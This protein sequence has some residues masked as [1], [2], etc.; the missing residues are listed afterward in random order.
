VQ[1][2]VTQNEEERGH[3]D[4]SIELTEVQRLLK[5]HDL[6]YNEEIRGFWIPTVSVIRRVAYWARNMRTFPNPAK[7]PLATFKR[8]GE[9]NA[10]A[11]NRM[12]VSCEIATA[13]QAVAPGERDDGAGKAQGFPDQWLSHR[14]VQAFRGELEEAREKMP[15]REH[16]ALCEAMYLSLYKASSE[17]GM[18]GSL[19]LRDQV[20]QV[21]NHASMFALLRTAELTVSGSGKSKKRGR[22]GGDG[23]SGPEKKKSR[24]NA[25][26]GGQRGRQTTPARGRFA[27]EDGALGPNGLARMRG[28]NPAGAACSRHANGRCA[29]QFCS[30]SH[31]GA[32]GSGGE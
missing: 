27:D 8:T 22:G 13:G 17:G 4:N 15:V 12:L 14:A 25:Q 18:T 5:T 10:T 16:D 24:G 2:V 31:A 21:S 6:M 26:A 7:L 28:G 30:F 32:A 20:T 29:F 23:A 19:T 1:Y 3:S 9:S 11:M